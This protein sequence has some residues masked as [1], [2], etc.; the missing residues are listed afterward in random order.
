MNPTE[1]IDD[2]PPAQRLLEAGKR[3]LAAEAAFEKAKL[4]LNEACDEYCEEGDDPFSGEGPAP[5]LPHFV[6]DNGTLYQLIYEGAKPPKFRQIP[7]YDIA[8]AP[9][10]G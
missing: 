6:W 2:L 9:A 8:V 1:T 4:E 5:V 3:Y 7:P 10:A